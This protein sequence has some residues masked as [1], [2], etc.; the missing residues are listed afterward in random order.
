MAAWR[1]WKQA[2]AGGALFFAAFVPVQWVFGTFLQSPGARNWFFGSNSWYY[3]LNP[4]W[5]YRYKFRP[6]DIVSWSVLAKGIFLALIIG[7]LVGRV[8]LRWGN[9]MKKIQR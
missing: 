8:S 9:W 1:N 4:D 2:L 5:P 6:V 7:T 3:A